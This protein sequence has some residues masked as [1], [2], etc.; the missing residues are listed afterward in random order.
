MNI[1]EGGKMLLYYL[2]SH[3]HTQLSIPVA[4]QQLLFEGKVLDGNKTMA[5]NGIPERGATIDLIRI[6]NKNALG[7]GQI[8]LKTLTN[9]TI[10]LDVEGTDTVLKVKRK[11]QAKAGTPVNQQRLIYAGTQLEDDRTLAYYNISR[12][13]TVHIVL[14]L[15][16]GMYHVA[17]GYKDTTGEFLYT[18]ASFNGIELAIHPCWTSQELIEAVKEAFS[19]DSPKD[20]MSRKFQK[21]AL[22]LH[23][24]EL[25]ERARDLSSRL[26]SVQHRREEVHKEYCVIC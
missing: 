15:A 16:G 6:V 19:S 23:A 13:S 14:R 22:A 9:E 3:I 5:D 2:Q 12:D 21:T 4:Q 8:F 20:V 17:S 11:L 24:K 25:D 18:M 26:D 1:P 10:I 7:S